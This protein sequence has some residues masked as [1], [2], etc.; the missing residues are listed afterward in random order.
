MVLSTMAF[1]AAIAVPRLS[2]AADNSR[3]AAAKATARNLQFAIDLYRAEHL[4]KSPSEKPDG[5]AET[6]PA[7]VIARL[8]QKTDDQGNTTVLGAYGPYLQSWPTNPF[9]GKTTLRIGGAL[10]GVGTHGWVVANNGIV[11][12]DTPVEQATALGGAGSLI[13]AQADPG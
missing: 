2:S 9:N 11:A 5:S 7:M 6:D 8:L 13:A 1:I 10:A 12:I 3:E 4:D